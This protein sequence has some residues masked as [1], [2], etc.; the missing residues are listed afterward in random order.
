ME[1]SLYI[2]MKYIV[3]YQKKIEKRSIAFKAIEEKEIISKI[4]F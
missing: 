2:Y 4:F 1:R 3:K